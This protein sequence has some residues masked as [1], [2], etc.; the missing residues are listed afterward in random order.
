MTEGLE[1]L[2]V[3]LGWQRISETPI[4]GGYAAQLTRLTLRREDGVQVAAVYKKLDPQRVQE[5]A[6]YRDILHAVPHAVPKLY[7]TVQEADE[8]GILIEAAGSAA[9]SLFQKADLSDKKRMLQAIV[10]MLAA[11]HVTL[12]PQSEEW[13]QAGV[14]SAYPFHSSVQWAEDALR[15]LAGLAE[16][17][18]AGVTLELVAEMREI[19]ERFYPMYPELMRGR[20]TFTHGDPHMENILLDEG[21][22]RLIDWEWACVAPPQRD[23][24]ILLQDV[25]ED[26]L[27][28]FALEVYRKHWEVDEA[29]FHACL[30]DN[31]LM[32]LGWEIYKYRGGHLSLAELELILE[33]KV[34]WIR[35]SDQ[36]ATL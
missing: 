3:R 9:K 22:Y 35:R 5:L 15:E 7:G 18:L 27:H 26:E 31:T 11:L 12:A 36:K 2:L 30:L 17:G 13:L 10:E 34:R 6:L 16:E 24:T 20:A 32:M 4:V 19:V 14:I 23:L 28:E 1:R 21:Q 8:Q 25:L 29:S 33:A